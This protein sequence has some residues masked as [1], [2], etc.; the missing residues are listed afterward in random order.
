MIII[1]LHL[2]VD[3]LIHQ[4]VYVFV[5]RIPGTRNLAKLAHSLNSTSPNITLNPHPPTKY[6]A[7]IYILNSSAGLDVVFLFNILHGYSWFTLILCITVVFFQGIRWR[8]HQQVL[9]LLDRYHMIL[10]LAHFHNQ[11][12]ME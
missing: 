4:I 11:K 5:T 3:E 9:F 10:K 1:N 12:L 6:V 2:P 8:L 7:C